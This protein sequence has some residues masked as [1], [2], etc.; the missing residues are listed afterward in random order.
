MKY[1]PDTSVIID[2]IISDL[3]EKKEI[4]GTILISNAV[5]SELENQANVGKETGLRGLEEIQNLQILVKKK[6]IELEFIG[7]RP[8]P[9][10]IR[11][12]KLGGEID[13]SIRE[14]AFKENAILVTADKVQA[15]SAKAF[16]IKVKFIEHDPLTSKLQIE[17]Y[18]DKSTMSVH[19][20]AN[21]YIHAKK[22]KP[23]KW[24]LIKISKKKIEKA[25]VQEIAKEII[26][27]AN[28]DPDS[29][30]EIYRKSSSVVQYKDYRIV[31]VKPPVSDGWEIT[32]VKPIKKLN[33]EDYELKPD[34]LKK[35]T[36][37]VI[38]TGQ[39]GSGKSTF[40]QALAE[41]F[42]KENKIVKTIESP[43]DLQ[44][45]DDITQYGKNFTANGELHDILF[46]TRPDHIVF[47]E[48]RDTPDF[49][50]YTDIRLA[51]SNMIGV[52]H[53]N[54]P[55]DAIQRFIGRLD[56][57]MIPS[58]LDLVIYMESGEIKKILTLQM[59]VKVPSGMTESD[60]ARPVI[61]VRDYEKDILEHEIYSYGD[62]TVVIPVTKSHNPAWDLAAREIERKLSKST[63]NVKAE[64]IDDRK[65]IVYVDEESVP[66]VIGR[67]GAHI[68]QIEK[69]LGLRISVETFTEENQKQ[70]TYDV[71]ENKKYILFFVKYTPGKKVDLYLN[72]RFFCTSIVGSKRDIKFN[73]RSD[74]GKRLIEALDNEED[75]Q[76]KA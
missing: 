39:V 71:S 16:D 59:K 35:L 49:K 10:Q 69:E 61:E 9:E 74:Q 12:A 26:D 13:A 29:F 8:T 36:N 18:F 53:S 70:I 34:I 68:E 43:R 37:G 3:I 72:D 15:E 40:C 24:D 50:L 27:R 33:L 62:E 51:G 47:D 32:A 64:V 57:G 19:M 25:E 56:T 30:I 46:L 22:G 11:N 55:I 75:I 23:G 76:I 60:L 21:C 6:K 63:E 17:K 4:K 44:L 73:K 2:Q 5:I 58:V 48:M 41:N 7:E 52:L 20:K 38:V 42:S 28:Y 67:K 66:Q 14:I 65:A 54:K 31:I 1:V 45:L